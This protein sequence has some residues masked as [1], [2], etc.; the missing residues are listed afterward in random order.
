MA[1][2]SEQPRQFSY[3][4]CVAGVNNSQTCL[5]V[6]LR[7]SGFAHWPTLFETASHHI[8][9]AAL[10]L[11]ASAPSAGIKGVMADLHCQLDYLQ[12]TNT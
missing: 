5:E 9:L 1:K 11:P 8:V 2:G 7:S 6:E 3:S 4:H 12:S 10:E